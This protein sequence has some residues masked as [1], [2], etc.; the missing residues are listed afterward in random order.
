MFV[1]SGTNQFLGDVFKAK[2]SIDRLD[3]MLAYAG[4]TSLVIVL[5]SVMAIILI[6]LRVLSAPYKFLLVGFGV[7]LAFA[8]LMLGVPE[9]LPASIDLW[10]PRAVSGFAVATGLERMVLDR[11]FW[12]SVCL[13]AF[14]AALRVTVYGWAAEVAQTDDERSFAF[15]ALFFVTSVGLALNPFISQMTWFVGAKIPDPRFGAVYVP[16]A[17]AILDTVFIVG[18]CLALV[19]I[20]IPAVSVRWFQQTNVADQGEEIGSIGRVPSNSTFASLAVCFFVVASLNSYL[21]TILLVTNSRLG[22]SLAVV[23]LLVSLGTMVGTIVWYLVSGRF[24]KTGTLIL[25]L[26]LACVLLVFRSV[27]PF[28]TDLLRWAWVAMIVIALN[29]GIFLFFALAADLIEARRPPNNNVLAPVFFSL[30]A[31]ISMAGSWI[32]F[33]ANTHVQFL[34]GNDWKVLDWS[35]GTWEMLAYR[36]GAPLILLSFAAFLLWRI[37]TR[38]VAKD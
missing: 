14:G 21:A 22:S 24:G 20:L 35:Q 18:A 6:G 25:A 2:Y 17:G 32:G 15:A 3:T 16:D 9:L 37:S 1:G 26:S 31:L 13:G 5:F 38:L 29:G 27:V 28:E 33:R 30:F 12:A 7:P 34:F 4:S 8:L 36:T 23:V 11:L 19:L 10:A